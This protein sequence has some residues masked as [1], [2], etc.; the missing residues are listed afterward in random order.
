MKIEE[1]RKRIDLLKREI[2]R[3]N[4]LYYK[5]N[6]PEISDFEYDILINQ[7]ETLEKRFPELRT[8][9]SPTQK[10]G[11][12]II[13]KEFIQVPHEY[14]MLSLA[15]TY[16]HEDLAEFDRRVKKISGDEPKYVCELKLD[17]AS[18]SLKYSGGRFIRAIT[19]G[20]GEKGDDV[21]SNVLTI[22]SV[23]KRVSGELMPDD[24]VIRGEI[25]IHKDDFR[26]MNE[27]RKEAGDQ[28][29][30][31]PRNAAAGTLKLL[32][33]G[34]VSR[35]PLDC[36]LYFLLST[37]LPTDS[38][39]EN[40]RL[41]SEW[42]FKVSD[43]M[44]ICDNIGEVVDYINLW[45]SK[46]YDIDYEI[47][48]VVVKADSITL[49]KKMGFTSKTPR[50]AV[51][52]KY[53]AEQEKTR[54]MSVSFQ[55][56]RTGAV[57]PVANLEPVLLAGTTVKRASL[58]N[59]DQVE[60]LDL[61]YNDMVYIE[62]GGEIIPKI[63]GVDITLRSKDAD[64]VVF[65]SYCPECK[66][67]LERSEGEAGWYCPNEKECPPQIKGK[68]EHFISRRAMNIE[69]LGEET[70][71]MLFEKGLVR[72]SADLYDLTVDKLSGLDRLGEKS[73]N[74]IVTSVRSSVGAPFHRLIF[75]LGIRHIG[76]TTARTVASSFKN[77]DRL[78]DASAEDLISV[79]DIGPKTAE[80][81]RN[82]FNDA[83]NIELIGRL[84]GHGLIMSTEKENIEEVEGGVL[85]GKS[86]VITGIF[87]NHERE[88]YKKIIEK[89]GGKNLSSVTTG[90]TFILAGE[91]P[92]PS[93]I[94]KARKL[95]IPVHSEEDFL[96]M[97][98][99]SQ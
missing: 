67:V 36:Y 66:S 5:E 52:Y 70:V 57:T 39:Y 68:I 51:A 94:E 86:I 15:N 56:G 49:Q 22:K 65:P 73:A 98:K 97:L 19:R 31:N 50:W 82:F 4:D 25:I 18:I 84:R 53:K 11:S 46:R 29:F 62:K 71:A 37:D 33:A 79:T 55:V 9:D 27:A 54:L 38:H 95:G 85:S 80:S 60:L 26:K 88:E 44:K 64:K 81:I 16:T 48:G 1:A 91:K 63:V 43:S 76:E 41:A 93:K 3:H 83:D 24:F 90:T 58:H 10:V 20:D 92:G 21:S 99:E 7:L 96:K 6:Q 12:D 74:N 40:M 42:G 45:E 77:I 35:R 13:L 75:A 47:D 14:P 87:T 34:L 28:P 69:G 32:D 8:E 17:G 30:A 59:A 2:E 72:D 61:H 78:M 89:H 23:P